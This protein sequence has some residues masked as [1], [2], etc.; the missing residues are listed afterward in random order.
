MKAGTITLA[1]VL[2][3]IALSSLSATGTDG[4]VPRSVS[5]DTI[6][7]HL[8]L[9]A[10]FTYNPCVMCAVPGDFVFFNA[11]WSSPLGR[12]AT[13][14][15]DFGDGSAVVKTTNAAIGH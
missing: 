7:T 11:N 1:A 6:P 8:G 2:L 13:F 10:A 5:A 9:L 3:L 4:V 14:A 12:I 15:W